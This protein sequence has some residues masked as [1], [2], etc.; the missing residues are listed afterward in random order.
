MRPKLNLFFLMILLSLFASA[1]THHKKNQFTVIVWGDSTTA[2]APLFRSPLEVPPNGKGN[3]ES[4]YSFW[5]SKHFPDWKIINSGL[6]GNKT[7]QMLK[8]FD[9]DVARFHPDVV[10]ILAGVNDLQGGFPAEW[11]KKN[12]EMIYQKADEKKIKVMVCTILP[13]GKSRPAVRQQMAEL[14]EW[15]RE[16]SRV[17][18]YGFCDTYQALENPN[19]RGSLK[20]TAD[21]FHPDVKGYQV[22][23]DAIADAM[24]K[25]LA[26]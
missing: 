21:G 13:M 2:G 24:K 10:V 6:S 20:S 25:W 14:N 18:G 11:V 19:G 3:K 22:L 1:C 5:L 23:G 12:L 7:T 17:K 16:I 4:Q 15:L 8:R 26:I 9:S